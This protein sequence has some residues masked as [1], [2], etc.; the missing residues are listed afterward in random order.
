M[1]SPS[2]AL[3]RARLDADSVALYVPRRAPRLG[4]CSATVKAPLH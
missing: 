2:L 4:T 1:L 3:A